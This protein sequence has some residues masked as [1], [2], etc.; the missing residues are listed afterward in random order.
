MG[1]LRA[2]GDLS[3]QDILSPLVNL[4]PLAGSPCPVGF[5]SRGFMAL[6]LDCSLSSQQH[7]LCSALILCVLPSLLLLGPCNRCSPPCRMPLAAVGYLDGTLAI[8]DLSTQSLRHKCQHEVLPYPLSLGQGVVF[9]PLRDFP[10]SP[11]AF[12]EP[13]PNLCFSLCPLGFP[14]GSHSPCTENVALSL[15]LGGGFCVC[16]GWQT[17]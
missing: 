2:A 10:W 5:L 7:A 14:K 8:Y 15:A 4:R 6:L 1:H 12:L 3:C 17:A 11:G 9:G 13:V 16:G